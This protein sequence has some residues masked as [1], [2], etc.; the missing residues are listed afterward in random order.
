MRGRHPSGV[1]ANVR[2]ESPR[3]MTAIGAFSLFGAIMAC[4]AGTTLIWQGTFLD[5]I[6][7]LNV[8]AY[9]QLSPFGRTMGIPFL[10]LSAS[11][12]A[13]GAGWFGRR[14]WGWRLAVVIIATQVLGDLMGIFMGHF[15]KGAV[16][17]GIAGALLFYLVRP[18]VRRAFV[19]RGEVERGTS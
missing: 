4:L 8:H 1:V 9:Q 10:V 19:P 13:A 18:E 5:H 12:A 16:G 17:V 3:A 15:I 6:W 14:L 11:L 2:G 7:T